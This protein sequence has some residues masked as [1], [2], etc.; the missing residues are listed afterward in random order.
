[1]VTLRL[2]RLIIMMMAKVITQS[3]CAKHVLSADIRRLTE[4]L[5]NC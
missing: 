1:M 4:F 2:Q 5:H 3:K